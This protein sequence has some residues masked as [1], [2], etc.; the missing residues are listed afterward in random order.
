MPFLVLDQQYQSTEHVTSMIDGPGDTYQYVCKY[1]ILL[2]IFV[3]V[4]LLFNMHI[5][6]NQFLAYKVI[7]NVP[8][9]FTI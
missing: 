9:H 6:I 2:C 8:I 5:F 4:L 1:D 7:L 3:L